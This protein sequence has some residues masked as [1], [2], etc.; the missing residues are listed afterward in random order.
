MLQFTENKDRPYLCL[1]LHH[2][3]EEREFSYTKGTEKALQLAEERGWT[4]VYIKKDFKTVFP[5][6][7]VTADNR[8]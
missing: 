4:V 5:H 2:D 1:L 6:E 7:L 8:P 3:D